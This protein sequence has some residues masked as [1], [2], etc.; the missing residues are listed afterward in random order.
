MGYLSSHDGHSAAINW[1]EESVNTCSQLSLMLGTMMLHK[2]GL[3]GFDF[4]KIRKER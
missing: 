1:I 3:R 2:N 4:H